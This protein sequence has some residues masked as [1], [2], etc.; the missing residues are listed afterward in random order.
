MLPSDFRDSLREDEVSKTSIEKEGRDGKAAS[1][2][3]TDAKHK[4]GGKREFERIRV[5]VTGKGDG[6]NRRAASATN[7]KPIGRTMYC[8]Y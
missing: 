8:C 6:T 4:K 7:N 5:A 2:G 1:S 3:E